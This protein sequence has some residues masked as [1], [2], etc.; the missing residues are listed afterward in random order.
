MSASR[1]SFVD[2]TNTDVLQV[3]QWSHFPKQS[4]NP[5]KQRTPLLEGN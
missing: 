4:Y 2:T 3:V 1:M 5:T